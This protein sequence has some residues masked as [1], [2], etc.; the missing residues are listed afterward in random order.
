M[1]IEMELTEEESRFLLSFCILRPMKTAVNQLTDYAAQFASTD[2]ASESNPT[3]DLIDQCIDDL[4]E[5]GHVY[6]KLRMK[7]AN[8]IR[9]KLYEEQKANAEAKM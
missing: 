8:C 3:F 4:N 5:A 1:K 9:S 6:E 7:M 2:A